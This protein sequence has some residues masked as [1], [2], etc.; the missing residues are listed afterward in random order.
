MIY[1]YLDGELDQTPSRRVKAHFDIC[2]RC[3]PHLASERSF[4]QALA[5]AMAG[6]RVPEGVRVRLLMILPEG[7]S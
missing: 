5:R 3:Y 1:E 2:E 6:Q 4:K 7:T